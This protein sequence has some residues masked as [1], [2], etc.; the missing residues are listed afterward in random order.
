MV[1]IRQLLWT[2]LLCSTLVIVAFAQTT[3]TQ[4]RDTVSNA[5]GT[6]FNGTVVITWN[7]FAG[8][9]PGTASPLST[10]A[11]IYN[12]ALS[13]LLVPT[14][15][16]S[17]GTFYQAVYYNSNGVVAWI[18]TW[19]VP[20]SGTPLAISTIRTSTST[21]P[22]GPGAPPGTGGGT[23]G[24]VQYATLPIALNQ[25]TGLSAALSGINSAINALTAQLNTLSTQGFGAVTNSVFID[26]E[27]P[28]GS[29]NG[30]NT[31]FDLS[32]TP[33][34]LSSLSVYR[35]G[36]FQSVGTDYT[37]SGSTITFLPG[38]T[39]R[40]TDTLGA[41]YRVA[42][43]TVTA[44]FI[45]AETPTGN[46]D[47]SNVNFTLV[48]APAPALSL[49]LYKNGVLLLQNTD[50]TVTGRNLVMNATVTPRPGDSLVAAY[51]H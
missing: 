8:S 26:A 5:D 17:A 7:G 12:G 37:L 34:P 48:F 51:R 36:L 35:N 24:G 25:I 20:P 23:S 44:S 1:K 42:G 45:D 41:Y 6:P 2:L 32:Q 43:T 9:N 29:I 13:V 47:G 49:K 22:G 30:V 19:Q 50:Y 16:A 31:S 18:E 11:R 27:A 38:S 33:Y 10:S 3:L 28:V 21:G 39:P 14:T 46:V 15:T 4:I 40:G